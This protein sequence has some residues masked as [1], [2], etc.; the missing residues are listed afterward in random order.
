[1]FRITRYIILFIIIMM[2]L[3]WLQKNNVN[4]RAG[5]DT[6]INNTKSLFDD[7]RKSPKVDESMIL[8]D[9]KVQDFS[10]NLGNNTQ[11]ATTIKS[12]IQDDSNKNDN[13]SYNISNAKISIDGIIYYTN[14]ERKKAGLLPL[15]KNNKLNISASKKVDDMFANQYFDHNSPKGD[16]AADIAKS[17]NYKFQIIGENL[18]LGIFDT[19]KILV[20][21]WMDSPTHRANILNPKYT[22]MGAA[23]GIS[24]YKG[25]K[26]WMAV[27]HF[28]KPM[29]VCAEV[30]ENTQKNIDTEKTSLESEEREL[31]KMAGVIETTPIENLER[32]YISNYNEKVNNYNQRLNNL[33]KVIEDFNKTIV[34]YNNC[35]NK[36]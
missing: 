32:N 4:V 22:E 21:A 24:D 3:F 14:L 23:V 25:Q 30:D 7:I 17:V 11:K 35:L 27:Q 15:T 6:I 10:G 28:G 26:Q 18:A 20:Q 34:D 2:C 29:P 1:M 12:F 31:Q 8:K 36:N 33:R 9:L 19:D 16:T 5:L 13:S